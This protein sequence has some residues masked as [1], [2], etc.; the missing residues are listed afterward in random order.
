MACNRIICTTPGGWGKGITANIL[1]T[2]DGQQYIDSKFVF[3]FYKVES[4]N[5]LS[6]PSEGN[7]KSFIYVGPIQ[8]IGAGFQNGTKAKC[9]VDKVAR[10][11]VYVT[12]N[13]V[14]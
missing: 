13:V 3:Y 14:G 5:P 1:I 2:F 12:E 11:P 7:G 4:V 10:S 6:G 8:V 9:F